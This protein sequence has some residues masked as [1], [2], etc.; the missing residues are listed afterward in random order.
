M[1]QG[2]QLEAQRFLNR[3]LILDPENDEVFL[4][5]YKTCT[6]RQKSLSQKKPLWIYALPVV[7][8]GGNL[9]GVQARA[10]TTHCEDTCQ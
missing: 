9:W 10:N 6:Q 7:T 2:K 3:L 4:I 5:Y 1:S 8:I